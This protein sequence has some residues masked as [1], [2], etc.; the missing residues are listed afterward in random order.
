MCNDCVLY[1]IKGNVIVVVMVVV[2]ATISLLSFQL[3]EDV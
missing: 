1:I 2:M 3:R